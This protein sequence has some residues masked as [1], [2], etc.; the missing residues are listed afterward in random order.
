VLQRLDRTKLAQRFGRT[1]DHR[2][3]QKGLHAAANLRRGGRGPCSRIVCQVCVP[4]V[5]NEV[6]GLL[7]CRDFQI[8]V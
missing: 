1:D 3:S 6:K 7:Q 8:R 4:P 2:G 5:C